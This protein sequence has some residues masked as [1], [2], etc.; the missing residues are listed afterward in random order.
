MRDDIPSLTRALN[1]SPQGRWHEGLDGHTIQRKRLNLPMANKSRLQDKS[2][3]FSGP[4]S[5]WLRPAV[6][7]PK[8]PPPPSVPAGLDTAR[9]RDAVTSSISYSCDEC[10]LRL[11][12]TQST[13]GFCFIFLLVAHRRDIA[14][15]TTQHLQEGGGWVHRAPVTQV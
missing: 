11:E 4:R 7:V 8:P 10:L 15:Q 12:V 13:G 9:Q 2:L 3:G 6:A 14:G 1:K 5:T